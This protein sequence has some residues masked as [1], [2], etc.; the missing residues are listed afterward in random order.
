M[1]G[2]GARG[3]S[4][5]GWLAALTLVGVGIRLGW[6][7]RYGLHPLGGEAQNVGVALAAGRGFADPY[8]VGSGPTAHL[9]P[10]TPLLVAA[11]YRLFGPISA[12][13][14]TLLQAIATAAVFGN[15]LLLNRLFRR[16]GVAAV[17]R[18][19][20]YA[21]LCL[22][23]LFL[24]PEALM[25]RYWDNALVLAA[26]LAG[27][28]RLLT[29]E[30]Q[31]APPSLAQEAGTAALA[32]LVLFASPPLG[33]GLGLG[34]GLLLLRRR[35]WPHRLR[36]IG[37]AAL[38]C[39]ALFGPWTARNLRVMGAPILLRDNAPL[40]LSLA[41]NPL[42]QVMP[43]ERAFWTEFHAIHPLDDGPG[44]ARVARVGELPYMRELGGAVRA[45]IAAHPAAFLRLCLAHLRQM[46][47]PP[48]WL[49]AMGTKGGAWARA[50]VADMVSLL[51][52]AGLVRG[53]RR[54]PPGWRYPAL[55]A[56]AV[57]VTYPP[58]QPTTRYIYPLWGIWVFAAASLFGRLR[59][60]PDR[61]S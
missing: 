12:V 3:V 34:C 31:A 18:V 8:F 60:E 19:A 43:P 37:L 23:P 42:T 10:T 38:A 61:P 32:A 40:E 22:V 7:M 53:L 41:N 30:R 45:W 4:E 57:V 16:L 17:P 56:G 29:L 54:G 55:L 35:D 5:R 11:V 46:L 21:L 27:L 47:V 20:G 2:S 49:F 14:E 39:L 1:A 25:F 26:A 36:P 13:S 50:A 44:R 51:G 59:H 28:H 48:T 15:F 6:A 52:M 33:L 24:G 58:F 9:M